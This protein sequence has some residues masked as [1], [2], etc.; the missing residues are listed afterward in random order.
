MIKA[1]D[2]VLLAERLFNFR[3]PLLK[4]GQ[5]SLDSSQQTVGTLEFFDPTVAGSDSCIKQD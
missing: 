3:Q 4:L 2:S 5:F 1:V